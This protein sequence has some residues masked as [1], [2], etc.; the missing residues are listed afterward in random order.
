MAR[1]RVPDYVEKLTKG[2]VD[3][4]G[5][6]A[7]VSDNGAA[8][9]VD[10]HNAMGQIAADFAMRTAIAAARE[11]RDVASPSCATAIIAAPWII[12]RRWRWPMA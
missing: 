12:G 11:N 1:L 9:V 10:A 4:R 3:P 5:K 2:G 6:P 8:I 7:I